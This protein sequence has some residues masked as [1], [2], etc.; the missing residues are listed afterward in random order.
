MIKGRMFKWLII[1]AAILF[2]IW[3]VDNS[4]NLN[5][6]YLSNLQ[7]AIDSAP[8]NTK[9]YKLNVFDCSNMS[10]L[11]DDWL[12]LQ[13]YH[14]QILAYVATRSDG[15]KAHHM[16]VI[17]DYTVLV[18]ATSKKIYLFMKI[19]TKDAIIFEDSEDLIPIMGKEWWNRE[20]NYSNNPYETKKR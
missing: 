4:R 8:Y 18:E 3:Y 6:A 17:V 1:W 14:T 13:G 19:P 12:E 15:S 9:D 5:A 7:S 2:G 10:N 20:M 16:M 11:L